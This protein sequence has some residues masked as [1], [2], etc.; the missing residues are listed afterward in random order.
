[1]ADPQPVSSVGA[2][3]VDEGRLLL[4]QRGRGAFEGFWA[5]PAGRQHYGETM[6]EAA[7]REVREETGLDVAV[8]DPVWVGD[9]LDPSDPPEYH[10]TVV[11][12]AAFVI[13]GE[14]R[15]G[16]DAVDARWV[17]LAEVRD[18]P[19]TPTMVE[20]LDELGY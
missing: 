17:D 5:I 16:D 11:D 18:L 15:A 8:G 13:G 7:V 4:I 14:L 19:L 6:E 9:I 1:V 2:V 3:I 20:M 10:Y 12:F